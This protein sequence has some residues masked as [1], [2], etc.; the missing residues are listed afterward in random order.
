MLQGPLGGQGTTGGPTGYWRE[1][2][3]DTEQPRSFLRFS[4]TRVGAAP[5]HLSA[6]LKIHWDGPAGT[7]SSCHTQGDEH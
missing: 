3:Y 4:S 1:A 6:I 5:S 7:Q 2:P